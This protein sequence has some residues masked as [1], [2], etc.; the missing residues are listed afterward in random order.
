MSPA[1]A[2]P[3]RDR[4]MAAL[5]IAQLALR[6]IASITPNPKIAEVANHALNKIGILITDGD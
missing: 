3:P 4:C 5:T 1:L 2:K 6:H